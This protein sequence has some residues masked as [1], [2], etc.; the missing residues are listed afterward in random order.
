MLGGVPLAP[1]EILMSDESRPS[2]DEE[3]P[4]DNDAES[5]AQEASKARPRKSVRARS[6]SLAPNGV[7]IKSETPPPVATKSGVPSKSG[8]STKSMPP[9]SIRASQT[10]KPAS[11]RGETPK[12]VGVRGETPK[13]A[14]ARSETPK[15]IGVRGETPRPM[16]VK[17]GGTK[18]RRP[19]AVKEKEPAKEKE[20][21]TE[22]KGGA[23]NRAKKPGDSDAAE[24]FFEEGEALAQAEADERDTLHSVNDPSTVLGGEAHPQRRGAFMLYVGGAV[25]F[26]AILC[27]AAVA[28]IALAH[29]NK[30]A[31]APVAV[32]PLP[33]TTAAEPVAPVVVPPPTPSA[34]ASAS[35]A[36]AEQPSAAPD[37]PTKSAA[38]EKEDARRA[39]ER[40]KLQDAIMAALRSTSIDPTDADAW[41][42]LGAAYQEAG[43]GADA[44]LAYS[45]CAKEA[46]RG[47]VR[48]C[49]LMLH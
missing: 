49:Q 31:E 40:G 26:C 18:S 38:E 5:G 16:S 41:L 13:P 7:S 42:L 10:P 21:A 17:T 1:P 47:E 20:L 36:P 11:V 3:A 34:V 12:P 48:E 43:K 29:A 37:L 35:A 15:P 4:D 25:A 28:R 19:P 24:K 39:L 9:R 14:N 27:L 23:K 8:V 22:A 45:E 46:K 33:P 2:P 30:P 32:A 44:R 6:N